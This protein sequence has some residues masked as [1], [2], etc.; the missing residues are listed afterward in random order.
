MNDTR[1]RV[2]LMTPPDEGP[3]VGPSPT[4]GEPP[5]GRFC[6]P[7]IHGSQ[8]QRLAQDRAATDAH[9]ETRELIGETGAPLWFRL[10]T[11]TLT[12]W[13]WLSGDE[14]RIL[15]AGYWRSTD[16]EPGRRAARQWRAFREARIRD[17]YPS[18]PPGSPLASCARAAR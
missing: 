8:P 6:A 9:D 17:L 1:M 16:P 14:E 10:A 5:G 11:V 7:V 18:V 3:A 12:A 13:I 4:C 2:T 15:S